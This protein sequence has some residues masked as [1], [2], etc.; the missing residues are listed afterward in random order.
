MVVT[1]AGVRD[2]APG[3]TTMNWLVVDVGIERDDPSTL[4]VVASKAPGVMTPCRAA[5]DWGVSKRIGT[6]SGDN[7]VAR[8]S[9]IAGH[10]SCLVL[11]KAG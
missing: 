1:E 2:E 4:S 8:G 11:A 5:A 3:A 7:Q 10:W 6:G 9:P